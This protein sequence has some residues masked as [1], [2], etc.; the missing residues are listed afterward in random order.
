MAVVGDDEQWLMKKDLLALPRGDRMPRLDLGHVSLIPLKSRALGEAV[1]NV[2]G[3]TKCIY[4]VYTGDKGRARHK[5]D[6]FS[7]EACAALVARSGDHHPS[8]SVLGNPGA[9]RTLVACSNAY[10]IAISAGSCHAPAKSDI[11]TGNPCT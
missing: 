10:A 3:H 5:S 11:P 4:W 2:D 8:S 6:G 9:R 1:A 7:L